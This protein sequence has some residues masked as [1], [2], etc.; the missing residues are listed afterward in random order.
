MA[1]FGLRNDISPRR[2]QTPGVFCPAWK[3]V[4]PPDCVNVMGEATS[5]AKGSQHLEFLSLFPV[6]SGWVVA[7]GCRTR[8]GPWVWASLLQ[9][10][11]AE[12]VKRRYFQHPP[13]TCRAAI[14]R[15][16]NHSRLDVAAPGTP[17][18]ALP[19]VPPPCPGWVCC[20]NTAATNTSPPSSRPSVR[21]SEGGLIPRGTF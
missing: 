16:L 7:R 10:A 12:V 14:P 9:Q 19:W 18:T 13:A 1:G 15:A 11:C 8:L 5:N 21:N 20:L 4:C 2:R 6:P 3:M 17:A